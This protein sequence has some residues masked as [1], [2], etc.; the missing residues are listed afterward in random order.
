M[1]CVFSDVFV[2]EL[3]NSCSY[4][5]NALFSK[6]KNFFILENEKLFPKQYWKDVCFCKVLVIILYIHP[7]Q[8]SRL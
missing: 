5:I 1:L 3:H 7:N 8:A 6:R 2:L 4:P